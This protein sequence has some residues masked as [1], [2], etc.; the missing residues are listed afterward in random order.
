MK[1]Q[2]PFVLAPAQNGER[3]C[4]YIADFTYM[5]NGKKIV[6]DVK[7]MRTREYIVKRKWFKDKYQNDDVIFREV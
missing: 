1:L 3:A 7:G 6:E 5:E 4:K 2:E